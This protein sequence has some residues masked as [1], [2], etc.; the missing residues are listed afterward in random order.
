M[1]W[2][3]SD[4]QEVVFVLKVT[5]I[6]MCMHACICACGGWRMT[7]SSKLFPSTTTTWVLK[8]DLGYQPWQQ[9][10]L[11]L[12]QPPY[13][14]LSLRFR[15]FCIMLVCALENISREKQRLGRTKFLLLC[16][17][18]SWGWHED[19]WRENPA[20]FPYSSPLSSLLFI[21]GYFS[22]YWIWLRSP[23]LKWKLQEIRNFCLMLTIQIHSGTK[24]S[25]H[26]EWLL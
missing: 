23:L 19:R 17:S 18:T 2:S 7:C 20:P 3:G 16:W 4:S 22:S 8:T 10:P 25:G 15:S 13:R 21:P 9:V 11:P 5:F 6:Y 26:V 12:E 24:S 14:A 1:G